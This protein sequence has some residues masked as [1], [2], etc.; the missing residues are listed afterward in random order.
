MT[1]E[2][3]TP[4]ELH[5]RKVEFLKKLK[6]LLE[7]YV[8][9]INYNTGY[10]NKYPDCFSIVTDGHIRTSWQNKTVLEELDGDHINSWIEQSKKD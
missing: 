5:A 7:D 8:A 4:E 6:K 1:S 3:L 9:A 2:N 10:Y